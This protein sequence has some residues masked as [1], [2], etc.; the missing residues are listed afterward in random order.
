MPANATFTGNDNPKAIEVLPLS[1]TQAFNNDITPPL[2]SIPDKINARLHIINALAITTEY[3]IPPIIVKSNEGICKF[4]K[5]LKAIKRTQKHVALAEMIT[6]VFH[7]CVWTME[8][9]IPLNEG[10]IL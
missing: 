7:I 3:T 2:D 10:A 1:I 8:L 9:K 5:Q 4:S 6:N